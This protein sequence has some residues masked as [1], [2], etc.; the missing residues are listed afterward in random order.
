MAAPAA[1]QSWL[2]LPG[3]SYGLIDEPVFGGKVWV[4]ELGRER[5][6]TVVLVHGIGDRGS[7]DW[8]RLLPELAE[9]YHVLALDLPGFGRSDAGNRLY[10]PENYSALLDFL[11]QR[12]IRRPFRLV[13]HSLGGAIALRFAADHPEAVSQLV[14]VDVA[15]ILHRTVYGEFLSHLG[16]RRLP[17]LFP[18]QESGLADLVGSLLRKFERFRPQPERVLESAESRERVL[19][20][21]PARIAGMALVEEDFSGALARVRAPTVILWGGADEIAPVRTGKLLA[22][23]ISGARLHVLAGVGH[24]PMQEA[25]QR[26]NALLGKEL[27]RTPEELARLREEA[28]YALPAAP[29][30]Q[31]REGSCAGERDV[32][33]R[34]D[35][36]RIDVRS[37]GNVK[38][39][40]VRARHLYLR[41]SVVEMEN[42]HVFGEEIAIRAEGSEL[43]ITGGS[44]RGELALSLRGS[45]VDL[46]GVHVLAERQAAFAD[47]RQSSDLLISVSRIESAESQVWRHEFITLQAGQSL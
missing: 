10:S 17:S 15:G 31:A 22:S 20:G 1:A 7:R 25:P 36:E 40:G 19:K 33:F 27:E 28:A 38:L 43:K 24:V 42:S 35:Y 13:G 23:T 37:C 41:G 45:R 6:E 21:E 44:V 32:V 18:G 16:I 3:A 46:A 26:F 30:V 14:L 8:D 4:Y 2:S 47:G 34:G 5:D 9:R 29:P 39:I 12:Y 11:A